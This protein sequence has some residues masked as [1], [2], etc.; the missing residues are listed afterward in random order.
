MGPERTRMSH[1][2]AGWEAFAKRI[3]WVTFEG[4]IGGAGEEEERDDEDD[5]GC[6]D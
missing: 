5:V 2:W 1:S 6:A 4:R 3:V